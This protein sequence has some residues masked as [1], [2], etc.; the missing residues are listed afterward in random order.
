MTSSLAGINRYT[1]TGLQN[2]K[3]FSASNTQDLLSAQ[4]GT[5]YTK[6]TSIATSSIFVSP[7]LTLGSIVVNSMLSSSSVMLSSTKLTYNITIENLNNINGFLLM[8]SSYY[9]IFSPTLTCSINFVQIACTPIDNQTIFMP[10]S[11]STTNNLIVT[12][13]NIVNFILPSNWTFKSVQT[14]QANGVTTYSD[15]DLYYNDGTALPSLQSSP[16]VMRII[17]PFNYVQSSTTFQAIIDS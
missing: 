7:Q 1:I 6:A 14:Y 5:P 3:Y 2:Q 17:L 15:V 8:F 16:M 9:Y 11:N 12:V 13:S 4:I 10:F